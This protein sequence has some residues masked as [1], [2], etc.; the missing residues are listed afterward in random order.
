LCSPVCS[1]FP[2]WNGPP[3]LAALCAVVVVVPE[4]ISPSA[5]ELGRDVDRNFPPRGTKTH[6]HFKLSLPNSATQYEE[7]FWP[8]LLKKSGVD[9]RRKFG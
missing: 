2:Y 8:I 7:R 6:T 1:A 9:R 5:G 3:A 4:H